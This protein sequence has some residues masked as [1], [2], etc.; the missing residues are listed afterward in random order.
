ML[1]SVTIITMIADNR[2][3]KVIE[4][5][6]LKDTNQIITY[7]GGGIAATVDAFAYKL[8]GH[9]NI[10]VYDG[11]MSEWVQSDDRPL[12]EGTEP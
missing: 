1:D 4:Q 8:L 5:K 9:D 6:N 7:C 10:S 2:Y 3:K 11:S 12:K